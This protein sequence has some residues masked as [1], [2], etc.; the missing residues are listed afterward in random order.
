MDRHDIAPARHAAAAAAK[1]T[2]AEYRASCWQS[3]YGNIWPSCVLIIHI[4]HATSKPVQYKGVANFAGVLIAAVSNKCS[5][6]W[7]ATR[8]Q[9]SSNTSHCPARPR[10]G[11]GYQRAG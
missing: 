11:A 4:A 5:H 10:S 9:Q 2:I 8:E 7:E 3:R 1:E 6:R